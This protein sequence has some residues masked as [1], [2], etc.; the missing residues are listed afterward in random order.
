[1]DVWQMISWVDQPVV[2]ALGADVLPVPRRFMEFGMRLDGWRPWQLEDKT[3]V[4]MP[5]TFDPI[6]QN[7][8]SLLL[9]LNGKPVAMQVP[10]SPYFDN[11]IETS[12]EFI[13]PPVDSI[14]LKP[15]NEEELEWRQQWAET[16]YAETDKAL[17]GDF[18]VNLGRWGSYQEWLY[19]IA[20]DP[21]WVRTW[22]DRKIELLLTDIQLYFQA[23]GDRI[24]AIYLMEDFGT[25]NS[26]LI[27]PKV[28]R[29]LVAPY[30]KRLFSWIHTNTRWKVF[31]HTD[32]AV[33]PIINDLIDCGIDILNPPQTNAKGMHPQKL[34]ADFGDRLAFW[35]AGIETQDLLPFGTKEE[36][37]T[38]VKD[39]INT[40]GRG[41]GYVFSTIHNI[42]CD[43]PIKNLVTL[44][45][46]YQEFG[47]YPLSIDE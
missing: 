7:D 30:Y 21:A 47:H 33:Y 37:R 34:K 31:F 13:P 16:L 20:A 45:E 5:M 22:Y 18:G 23:V 46:A 40:F 3:P 12:M 41:G 8:G 2:Q 6:E 38:Q 35:G 1:M 27:S 26:M 36:I 9:Y 11:L 10:G 28:F 15:F 39:R 32:G 29:E 24:A 42:Q 43:V 14:P 4:Q 25:Q 44:Y 17:V 19:M